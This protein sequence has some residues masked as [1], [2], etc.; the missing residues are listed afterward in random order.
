MLVGPIRT[1]I[2]F[3]TKRKRKKEEDIKV[4]KAPTTGIISNYHK[5][6]GVVDK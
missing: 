5:E 2:S 6:W 3:P 1:T 4:L